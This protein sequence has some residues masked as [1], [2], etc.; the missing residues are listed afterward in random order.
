MLNIPKII[1]HRGVKDIAPENTILSINRAIE[2]NLRWI[3]IDVKT[4]KDN[5]PFLLH[6]DLLDRTTSGKGFPFNY[7][8]QDIQNLDAGTW[9]DPKL[10]N[11]YPPTLKEILD[12]CSKKN[13]GVNIELKPNKTKE[14]INV[15]AVSNLIKKNNFNCQYFFSSF[16]FFSIELMRSCMPNSY[17][18]YLINDFDN[19]N[20]LKILDVCLN[21]K[22]FCIGFN[23]K[24]IN[25][26]IIKICRDNKLKTTVYADSNIDLAQAKELWFLGVDS[27]FIDNPYSYFK[28]DYNL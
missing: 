17:L 15:E 1:G 9:F 12:I 25:K 22:C 5:I 16:D 24:I 10:S 8:I 11:L 6:D 7:N 13:I 18:G 14:K 23:I 27:V 3:E 21:L 19:N 2:H 20:F 4:S 28:T 26:K